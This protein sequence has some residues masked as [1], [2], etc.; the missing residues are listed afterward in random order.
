MMLNSN[1]FELKKFIALI[2]VENRL[3]QLFY[4]KAE[5]VGLNPTF[6]IYHVLAGDE[7]PTDK[8]IEIMKKIYE[9]NI[10]GTSYEKDYLTADVDFSKKIAE[11]NKR[12]ADPKGD[13]KHFNN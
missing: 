4:D 2:G 12:R 5:S 3:M 7:V 9:F 11:K 13:N 10:K 6:D 1:K 8:E